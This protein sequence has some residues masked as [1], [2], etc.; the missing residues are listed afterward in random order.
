MINKVTFS[1]FLSAIL[2]FMCSG[3]ANGQGPASLSKA[4]T[5][6]LSPTT[7]ALQ[8]LGDIS[9]VP[10][11]GRSNIFDKNVSFRKNN[12]DTYQYGF[13]FDSLSNYDGTGGTTNAYTEFNID[14][15]ANNTA[16]HNFQSMFNLT[17]SSTI[18]AAIGMSS[19]FVKTGTGYV[20]DVQAINGSTTVTAGRVGS[21]IYGIA[22][23]VG[24]WG[25]AGHGDIADLRVG[26]STVSNTTARSY[27]AIWITRPTMT[28]ATFTGPVTALR[29]DDGLRSPVFTISQTGQ[30]RITN[31]VTPVNAAAPCQT[32]EIVWDSDF[33]YVC[34]ATD[35]WKR[36]MLASW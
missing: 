11:L 27:S 32:G 5:N 14:G 26:G 25:G 12:T 7:V 20:H 35:T 36:T 28:N 1:V 9:Y 16:Y 23:S 24:I 4:C 34:V 22:G 31:P 19:D 15:G 10:C 13:S 8:K 3:V 29:V 30:I 18:A 33:V 6:G 2:V 17:T 21:G